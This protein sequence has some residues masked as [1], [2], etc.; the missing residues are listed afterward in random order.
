MTSRGNLNLSLIAPA[1]FLEKEKITQAINK[2]YEQGFCFKAYREFLPG[3]PSFLMGSLEDRLSELGMAEKS[4][5]KAMMAVRG[6]TGCLELWHSY[7]PQGDKF[8]IGYSD[9]TILMLKRFLDNNNNISIHGPVLSDLD[10]NN[11]EIIDALKNLILINYKNISYPELVWSK[12]FA[13]VT[14][15]SEIS[16]P[17]IIM[18][19]ASLQSVLGLFDINF[20]K[21]KILAIE[22]IN[23]PHYRVHRIIHQLY[24]LK[25]FDYI[26]GLIVGHFSHDRKAIIEQTILPL[27]QKN[28][29]PVFDWPIFGHDYPN[30]P[31]LF[32]ARAKIAKNSQGNYKLEYEP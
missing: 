9:I 14:G 29:L 25:V 4:D 27:A 19:L 13:G 7:G 18:N 22:D 32:G 17:L 21:G 26:N 31:L 2:A 12:A 3:V 5:S 28:C 20:F 15:V 16:G 6:G 8:L 23:E 24:N 1:G 10:R 11:Q 30:Y